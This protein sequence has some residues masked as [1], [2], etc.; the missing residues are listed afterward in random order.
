MRTAI[1]NFAEQFSYEP[2]IENAESLA[3]FRKYIVIGM[4]GSH[5]AAGL[6]KAWNPYL[7]VIIHSDYGLSALL[8]EEL[9]ERLIILSSYS[10]NTEEVLDAFHIAEE[11]RL[12]V[13]V[14]ATGGKLLEL[15]KKGRAPYIEM[16]ET[17]IQP[18]SALGLGVKAFLKLMGEEDALEE[19][20]GL[21]ETLNP[22]TF[23]KEGKDLAK[24]LKDKVPVVYA[25]ARNFSIAY[26]WKIKLNETGKIPAFCNAIPE[27]NHNEMTGFDINDSSKHLSERFAFIILKDKSDHPRIGKRM[28]ISEKLYKERGFPVHTIELKGAST[29]E[30]IFSSIILADWTAF[31]TAETYGLEAEDIPMVRELKDLMKK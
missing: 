6:L 5:L 4:G 29:F 8:E 27:M 1:E 13:A 31:Y 26:T 14:I 20:G 22:K 9:Q 18:R 16:P 2:K 28:E 30:K 25:S 3:S 21:A 15:A 7:D 12:R 11:K 10:G 19:V 24:K 17:G 23:E